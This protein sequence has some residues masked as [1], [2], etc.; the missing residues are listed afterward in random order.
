MNHCNNCNIDIADDKSN[1][2][3]CGK[4]TNKTV[5]H[6]NLYY[7][8]YGPVVD[9]REPLVSIIQKVSLV[10]L[11]ICIIINLCLEGTVKFGRCMS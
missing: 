11:I 9:K 4:S 10:G 5:E 1:C 3:L 2:I 8:Q 6:K 7:P